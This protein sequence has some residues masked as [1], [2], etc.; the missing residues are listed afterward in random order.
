MRSDAHGLRSR[1]AGKPAA[2]ATPRST[3][4]AQM[5]RADLASGHPTS[6]LP[7]LAALG[8]SLGFQQCQDHISGPPPSWVLTPVLLPCCGP[9]MMQCCWSWMLTLER[10]HR[11]TSGFVHAVTATGLEPSTTYFYVVGSG[12]SLLCVRSHVSLLSWAFAPFAFG[13]GN[14]VLARIQQPLSE[15]QCAWQV[16][17]GAATNAWTSWNRPSSLRSAAVAMLSAGVK[18]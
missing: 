4:T 1:A 12:P 2:V 9:L 8:N 10:C 5:H 6:A 18:L 7:S 13:A 15:D 11:S 14:S 17:E 3:S 16:A